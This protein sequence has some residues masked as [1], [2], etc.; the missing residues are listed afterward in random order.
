MTNW[1]N[2]LP[3]VTYEQTKSLKPSGTSDSAEA[4]HE[5]PLPFAPFEVVLGLA[6]AARPNRMFGQ[7]ERLANTMADH[8]DRARYQAALEMH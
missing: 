6:G 5:E 8:L 7:A 4:Y 3:T 1:P 2:L